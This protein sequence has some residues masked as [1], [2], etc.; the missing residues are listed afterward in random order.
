MTD[1][2]LRCMWA[3]QIA[4]AMMARRE[5][6]DTTDEQELKAAARGV[7]RFVAALDHARPP[8][9]MHRIKQEEE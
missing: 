2:E 6:V 4:A 8:K 5:G 7:W 1:Y 9:P 3:G